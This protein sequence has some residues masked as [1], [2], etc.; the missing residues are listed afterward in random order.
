MKC[1]KNRINFI[2]SNHKLMIE[3]KRHQNKDKNLRVCP[4]CPNAIEDKVYFL[5][6]GKC[7]VFHRES[8]FKKITKQRKRNFKLQPIRRSGEVQNAH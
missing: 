6:T 3:K 2:L 8:L 5:I 7:F 4:F 1:I